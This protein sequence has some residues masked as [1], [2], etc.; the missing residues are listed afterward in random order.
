MTTIETFVVAI[1]CLLPDAVNA[2]TAVV[3]EEY[4]YG[5]LRC[6]KRY[7]VER[8]EKGQYKGHYRAVGQTTNPK[9]PG[10]VWNTPHAGTYSNLEVLYRDANTGYIEVFALSSYDVAR[11]ERIAQ[12]KPFAHQLD[13]ARRELLDAFERVGRK[14]YA[15]A[16][17]AWDKDN[18]AADTATV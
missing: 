14:H 13:A 9:K 6:K 18:A 8:A 3:V 7:W 10:E 12:L 15:P 5:S 1:E 11:P 17:E 4:P 16:W 2:E